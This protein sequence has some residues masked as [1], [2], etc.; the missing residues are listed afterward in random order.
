VTLTQLAAVA[1]VVLAAVVVGL[2]MRRH[3]PQGDGKPAAPLPPDPYLHL[4]CH[5]L[6]CG[7]MTTRHMPAG[8]GLAICRECG[9]IRAEAGR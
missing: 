2:G 7:H 9:S 1:L 6:S 3:T 4:P 5:S 8:D